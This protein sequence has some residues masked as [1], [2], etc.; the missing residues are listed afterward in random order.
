MRTAVLLAFL[1]A[2]QVSAALSQTTLIAGS[3][4]LDR[5]IQPMLKSL[6]E[7][8]RTDTK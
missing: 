3:A 1:S 6:M 2:L 4:F 5:E 8:L 7:I